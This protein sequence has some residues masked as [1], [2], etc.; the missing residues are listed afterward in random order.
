MGDALKKHFSPRL[1]DYIIIVGS[2]QPSGT[3]S[4]HIPELLRRYPPED[5]KDFPLPLDVVFFCQPEGCTSLGPRR[6]SLREVNSFVFALTEKDANRVR[7]GI[8]VNFYR[9]IEKRS[10]IGRREKRSEDDDAAEN[11][12]RT[13]VCASRTISESD[14]SKDT[15]KLLE[16]KDWIWTLL[17]TRIP[18]NVNI[19]SAI[20]TDVKE[21]E[22]L[23][24]RLLSAPVCV[25]GKTKVEI[26][27]LPKE[28]RP[29]LI[30]ALPDHTRFSLVDFPLHLP[31]E[32][33][34]VETCM[35]VLTCILLEHKLVLQSRDYNALSMS[36]MA[37]VT[38]IYPLEYMFPVIPLLPTCMKSAEQLL[39][40]PTP[41]IIGVPASFLMFKKNFKLPDDVWLVDLD[42]NKVI[43]PSGVEDLPSLP[44]PEGTVLT[45]HLK[46]ALHSMSMNPQPLKN[47]D[48]LQSSSID[49]PSPQQTIQDHSQAGSNRIIYGNDVDSVDVAT[50]V[51]MVR[52]FNSP[53]LLANFTEHTR[54]IK[55][56]P[57]PVVAF[58]VNSFLQSRPKAS[59][60]LSKFVRTQA[61]EFFAEWALCPTNVAFL[62]VQ[63]GV[64]DP[65]I[66]GDKAKWFSHQLDQIYFKV[67]NDANN[68]LSAALNSSLCE[69]G[70]GKVS[71]SDLISEESGSDSDVSTSSSYSSLSDFVKEMADSEICS[72]LSAQAADASCTQLLCD[73]Q[74]IFH[75]PNELHLAID[76]PKSTIP[77][78][79]EVTK[80]SSQGSASSSPTHSST[81]SSPS[82]GPDEETSFKPA[83]LL[84][85]NESQ[86]TISSTPTTL[87]P[88]SINKLIVSPRSQPDNE[89]LS[90]KDQQNRV[91][92]PQKSHLSEQRPVSAE[93][94]ADK[95]SSASSS[96]TLS[97]TISISSVFS[98]AGSLA[99]VGPTTS[100]T[101]SSGTTSFLDRF[102]NE[103]KE[104][105]REAKAAAVGASKSALEATKKE[106]G[107]K[108]LLKNLQAFGDPMKDTARDLWRSSQDRE[109]SSGRDTDS[110]AG[111]IISS[112]S[113]DF[114]GF[115]DKTSSML[116]GLFGSKATNLAE[117]VKEKAQPF[118]PFPKVPGRKGLVERT[119]LIRHSTNQQRRPSD[120]IRSNADN[121]STNRYEN[122]QFIKE[123]VNGVLEGEGVGW[124]KL[125]RFKKLM[126]DE[127]YRNQVVTRLNKTLE[128]KVGPDDH[129]EDVCIS[130]PVWKGMLKLITAMISGLEQSYIHNGLGGM[131]S[132][133]SILEI[134]H[135]HYWTKE[136]NDDQ[137]GESSVATTTSVSQSS[138]PFGSSEN[139]HKLA[140]ETPTST[141]QAKL[142]AS[143]QINVIRS[144]ETSE[145]D[146]SLETCYDGTGAKKGN[147][148][149]KITSI[150]SETSELVTD[151]GV[152]SCN[153]SDAGSYTINPAYFHSPRPSQMSCR[154]TY[155]DSELEA[156]MALSG[157]QTRAPSIWSSKS[158]VSTGYRY[159]GGNL[160]GSA[161]LPTDAQRTYL[162]QG[163][164][165]KER[166]PLWDQMQFWEDAFLDAVSQ[167]REMIGMDQGPG[168]MMERYKSL[169]DIDKKR[170]EH[171]EDRLLST[172]LYN[173][174]AFMVMVN[175]PRSEIKKKV[176]RLLGKCHISVVYSD[177]I[178]NL[179]DGID[180]LHGNDIDLKPL[181]SRQMHRQT[182][183]VHLGTDS[184]GEMLFMEVRDDG[185]ILRS[186]NGTIVERWWYERVVNMT[187]SPKNKVLCLW[188]RNGGQT[189][190]HK[191]YTRKCKELYYCIK[192]AME[193]AAARGAGALPGT[194]LGG[195]FPVQDMKTGEGGLLQVCI[196]GVGLLFAHSKVGNAF[197]DTCHLESFTDSIHQSKWVL[198]LNM[199][200]RLYC[201]PNVL[202]AFLASHIESRVKGLLRWSSTWKRKGLNVM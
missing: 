141:L 183:S 143:S 52:F 83:N 147:P 179:L 75:P 125:N 202:S 73:P 16:S 48:V 116:S 119:S 43:K 21:I 55:L 166:S 117:R 115:A 99:S 56:Y 38:M 120:A 12:K 15:C 62:R 185:L 85:D 175:V 154:S 124:L 66:I 173:M 197:K 51:A 100:S 41:Y 162:F 57:R 17:T 44:Q 150:D 112:V 93:P 106:V 174:V 91:G 10:S 165:G 89:S 5:H 70:K 101:H 114:N 37:F 19:P 137:R 58:Q 121:R 69:S 148:L 105:A 200:L 53:S 65:A 47:M 31:L 64:F 11:A 131:A 170:L 79:G 30:F 108:N 172:L 130:K 113:S 193:R 94:A 59:V 49:Q 78:E 67:W 74:K 103:A 195:E 192:E 167:E 196:E 22:T 198:H 169:S 96:P 151:A 188:R 199:H 191:Y 146:D 111:S 182:F 3:Q 14:V 109:E 42:S 2:R 187:Y 35:K 104:V 98:R 88:S 6:M 4:V 161:A 158:S 26:E 50:R 163:L 159:H 25:P 82:V 122:Q 177:E 156:G 36:V 102:A 153:T 81:S 87:T 201:D 84:D 181:A 144:P 145:T 129:I 149:T 140:A 92:T 107:K 176:R 23:L 13:D 133:L 68:S 126:E 134:A 184:S 61:V 127:N 186:I 7:Y 123:V 97:R 34:G 194:E 95:R 110:S 9:P 8:C 71:S 142:P 54:T 76:K 33:L 136:V 77:S 139:L 155:S 178:N 160:V 168:E 40:A 20:I 46:Q 164:L 180:N 18:E 28:I 132:S 152:S 39:L 90:D 72:D 27:V 32:L 45:T 118:G 29:P 189:Q 60:F 86:E 63:T 80:T 24:L 157:R 171:E 135:T 1:L 128:R 138:S 190:W